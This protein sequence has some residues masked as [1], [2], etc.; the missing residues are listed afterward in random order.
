MTWRVFLSTADKQA[1]GMKGVFHSFFRPS[2]SNAKEG[3]E[4]EREKMGRGDERERE[5]VKR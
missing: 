5:R 2:R 1:H 3:R 4:R